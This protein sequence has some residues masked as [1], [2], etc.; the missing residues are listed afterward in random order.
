[1][2]AGGEPSPEP[3]YEQTA[4]RAL[5]CAF[6]K[7][8]MPFLFGR[9]AVRAGV[10]LWRHRL[11]LIVAGF[12]VGAFSAYELTFAGPTVPTGGDC[13]DTAMAALTHADDAS[14][15]AAYACLGPSMRTSTEDQFVASL[16]QQPVTDGQA[17]RVADRETP[18]GKIVFFTVSANN[19]SPV[20]YIVYLDQD[21][22]VAKVE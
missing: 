11:G 12:T 6:G 19:I 1:V 17:D 18:S 7:M 9:V 16:Q 22:K 8:P 2:G 21:G 10:A 20:G 13:A 3:L 15:R 5:R 4:A 14:A